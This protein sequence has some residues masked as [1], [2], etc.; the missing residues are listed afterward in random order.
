M[1]TQ[2]IINIPQGFE[3]DKIEENK[4]ILK[5]IVVRQINDLISTEIPN[6]ACCINDDGVIHNAFGNYE[7][8]NIFLNYKFAKSALAMG[9]I[10]MLLPYYGG[11]ITDNEWN[12]TDIIKYIIERYNNTCEIDK[13]FDVYKLLAFHTQEQAEDFLANNKQLVFDYYCC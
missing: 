1:D 7:K 13:T 9:Q 2:K 6:A 3:F 8:Q 12:D 11:V 10:S 5:S 4:I